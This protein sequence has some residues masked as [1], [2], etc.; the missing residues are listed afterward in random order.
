MSRYFV[1]LG[2]GRCEGFITDCMAWQS[3]LRESAYCQ[4]NCRLTAHVEYMYYHSVESVEYIH[5]L[6]TYVLEYYS[7][8]RESPAKITS[9]QA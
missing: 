4:V 3:V 7:E 9:E 8:T 2:V 1:Y 6:D 5:C